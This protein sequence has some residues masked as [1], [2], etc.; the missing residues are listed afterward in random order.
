MKNLNVLP[1][2]ILGTVV[3]AIIGGVLVVLRTLPPSASAQAGDID[4]LYAAFLFVSG[5]IF[6]IVVLVML[7]AIFRF[8]A[9]PN[10]TR[11]G[12]NLHG[13]TWLEVLWTV[14]PFILVLAVAFVSWPLLNKDN[15]SGAAEKSGQRIHITAYQFGWKFTYLNAGLNIKD[16]PD[17]VVPVNEPIAFDITTMDVMH[18]FWVPAWRMQMAATPAQTNYTSATPTQIGDYDIVCAFLCGIGHTQMNSAVAGGLVKKVRVV[19]KAD[20]DAWVAKTQAKAAAS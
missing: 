20:F 18:S 3:G 6:G 1:L 5:I 12:S 13:I 10:D 15:V 14:I 9:R 7:V 4:Q 8:R 2:A 16:S 11:D 17:L 19:S